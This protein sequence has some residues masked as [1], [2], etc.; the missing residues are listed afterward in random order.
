MS[1]NSRILEAGRAVGATAVSTFHALNDAESHY[2]P[3]APYSTVRHT[4][5]WVYYQGISTV[6]PISILGATPLPPN[7][8][9]TLQRRGWR[10]GLLGWEIGGWLGGT[11][12][13]ELD[14]TPT[15]TGNWQTMEGRK[16]AQYD[17]EIQDFLQSASAP[18]DHRV[19]ETDFVHIPVSAGDG[20]F[21]LLIKKSGKVVASTASFRVGSLSLSSAHPRGASVVTIIPEVVLKSASVTATTAAWASFY[22]AFPFMKAAQILPGTSSWGTWALNRAYKL[23]GGEQTAAELKE[24]YKIEERRMRVE[25][26]V[27][28]KVPFGSV[29]VRTAHDLQE[30]AKMGRGGVYFPRGS[31]EDSRI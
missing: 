5:P 16:R 26:S 8:T 27:Y 6:V 23:A 30:D 10:T 12:G 28:Q 7:R 1:E 18:K 17:N 14:V 29:G 4:R 20:Y 19:L 31:E 9:I 3:G 2:T 22:A 15:S 25:E 13:K 11:I 24:R 21:R